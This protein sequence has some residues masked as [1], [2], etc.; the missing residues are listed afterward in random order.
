M[1]SPTIAKLVRANSLT[2]AQRVLVLREAHRY[3]AHL[4]TLLETLSSAV[5]DDLD[6]IDAKYGDSDAP[7]MPKAVM[8]RENHLEDDL[9]ALEEVV[10]AID[11]IELPILRSLK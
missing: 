8:N 2:H 7:V 4:S 5:E 6:A 10:A 1:F 3:H 9:D 11:E